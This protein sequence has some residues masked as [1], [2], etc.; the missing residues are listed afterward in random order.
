MQLISDCIVSYQGML[1]N[2]NPTDCDQFFYKI[3]IWVLQ[4]NQFC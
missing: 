4:N 2:I 1:D 3:Q